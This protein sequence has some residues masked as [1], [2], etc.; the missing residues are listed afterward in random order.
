MVEVITTEDIMDADTIIEAITTADGAEEDIEGNMWKIISATRLKELEDTIAEQRA[1][2]DE[3]SHQ[4]TDMAKVNFE[5]ELQNV[6]LKN[7]RKPN[8]RPKVRAKKD[9]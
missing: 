3:M 6:S 8:Q 7:I 2:I 4:L 9:A 1:K 5:L